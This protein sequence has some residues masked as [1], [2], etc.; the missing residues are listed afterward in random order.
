MTVTVEDDIATKFN[1]ALVKDAGGSPAAAADQVMPAPPRKPDPSEQDGQPA[2]SRSR[3]SSRSKSDNKARVTEPEPEPA[4]PVEGKWAEGLMVTGE[5]AWLVLSLNSGIKVGK[6][7]TKGGPK[8]LLSLPDTRP[9]AA[10]LRQHMPALAKTWGEA[11]KQN[12]TVRR[13]VSKI[14][15]S[16]GG[17]SWMLGVAFSSAM[18]AMGCMSLGREENAEL[19]AHLAAQNDQALAQYMQEMAD[20]LG[21]TETETE[22]EEQAA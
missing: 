22:T 11:A 4:A 6:R 12:P 5:Q 14:A 16:G 7:Q 21:L 15:G 9:Y 18:F 2:T 17:G 1:A 13:Y 20:A 19:R 8:P 10:M 3:R